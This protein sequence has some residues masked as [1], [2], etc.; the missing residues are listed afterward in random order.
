MEYQ[1]YLYEEQKQYLI[2]YIK[3]KR[4]MNLMILWFSGMSIFILVSLLL[5][6]AKYCNFTEET[7]IIS[8]LDANVIYYLVIGVIIFILEFIKGYGKNFGHNCDIKC[9]ENDLYTLDYRNFGYREKDTGHHPY[10]ICDNLGG[11]YICPRFLDYR[12]ADSDSK[13]LYIKLENGRGYAIG[14]NLP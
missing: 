14:E 10:Y 7:Q 1:I 8:E 4:F 5:F 3:D 13:F 2:K 11:T 9:I 6:E 12:N